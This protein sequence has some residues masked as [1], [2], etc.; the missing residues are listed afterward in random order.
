MSIR[1][2]LEFIT[3]LLGSRSQPSPERDRTP[4]VAALQDCPPLVLKS[5]YSMQVLGLPSNLASILYRLEGAVPRVPASPV[6]SGWIDDTGL[7][8]YVS[9]NKRSSDE[10]LGLH[11]GS[12]L[13]PFMERIHPWYPVLQHDFTLDFSS[14]STRSCLSHLVVAV[15]SLVDDRPDSSHYEAA[16]SMMANVIHECTVMS[17]QCLVLFS[18]YHACLLQPRQSYDYVQAANL[19]L[20]PFLKAYVKWCFS[21]VWSSRLIVIMVSSS[22]FPEGSPDSHFVERLEGTIYL[23]MRS[24]HAH[25]NLRPGLTDAQRDI[26]AAES[27]LLRKSNTEWASHVQRHGS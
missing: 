16:L 15:S 25:Y 12:V 21:Y 13:R 5:P 8:L 3:P 26:D 7:E 2:R 22:W 17:V 10:I 14:H 1:E 11:N 18:I 27:F 20:Q 24:V 6:N 19:K 23:I 4:P 9:H